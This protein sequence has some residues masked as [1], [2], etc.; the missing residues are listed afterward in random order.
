MNA[1]AWFAQQSFNGR[2]EDPKRKPKAPTFEELYGPWICMGC[3]MAH[4]L[5]D[6]CPTDEPDQATDQLDTA[7]VELWDKERHCWM[8]S[9]QVLGAD[10]LYHEV[11]RVGREVQL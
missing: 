3:G 2:L 6:P 11:L 5:G 8:Q 4:K 10:G 9:K 1:A 7:I